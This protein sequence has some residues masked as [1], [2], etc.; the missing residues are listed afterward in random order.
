M[1]NSRKRP[2][3]A[4]ILIGLLVFQAVSAFYGMYLL[5]S[6]PTGSGMKMENQAG[7]SPTGDFL[8]PGLILGILLGLVP[9]LS[10]WG[11]MTRREVKVFNALNVYGKKHF[12][13]WT[14]AIYTGIMLVIWITMQVQFLGGGFFIQTFYSLL[15]VAILIT[16]LLPSVK[17]WYTK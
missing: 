12:W 5:L 13:G 3:S 16:A 1:N 7:K 15:G 2:W 8:V 9:L 6:D 17:N 10:A 4:W 11:L 14:W